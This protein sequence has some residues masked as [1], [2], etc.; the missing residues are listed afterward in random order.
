MTTTLDALADAQ[1]AFYS[2]RFAR[3]PGHWSLRR[4]LTWCPEKIILDHYHL[5]AEK[6]YVLDG[7]PDLIT[8]H[9]DFI[10]FGLMTFLRHVGE[11]TFEKIANKWLDMNGVL[12]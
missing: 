8:N 2:P 12:V 4:D 6:L 3:A 11:D 5:R 9:R 1:T 7:R 10:H